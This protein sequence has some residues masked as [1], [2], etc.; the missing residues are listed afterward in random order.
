[1]ARVFW[2]VVK[3]NPPTID[4]FLSYKRLGRPFRGNPARIRE[5][6]ALSVFDELDIAV[7]FLR[8]GGSRHGAF[9]ARLVVP[10][11]LDLAI[12]QTGANKNHYSIFESAETVFQWVDGEII[13]VD[14]DIRSVRR[15]T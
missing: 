12:E 15:P 1:M 8:H 5:W 13:H 11:E 14:A 2:R 4:D 3:S 7:E 6:D 9:L 10:D